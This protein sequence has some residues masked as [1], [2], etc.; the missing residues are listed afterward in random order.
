MEDV[1]DRMN[2]IR[3][4]AAGKSKGLMINTSLFRQIVKRMQAFGLVTLEIMSMRI[5]DNVFLQT[6]I[7]EDEVITA[8]GRLDFFR[9]VCERN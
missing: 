7:Y 5:T 9:Q 8:F 6:T 3:G 1:Q 2:T 4:H